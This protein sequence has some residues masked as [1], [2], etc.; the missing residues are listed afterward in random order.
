VHKIHW[1]LLVV[2]LGLLA[3][4][5]WYGISVWMGTGPI[6]L[7]RNVILVVATALM[8][9]AG[10]GLIALMFYSQRKGY[11]NPARSDQTHRK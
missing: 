1:L 7:Y 3:F 4:V 2:L 11:D 6:P 10:C 8:F 9:V 5:A